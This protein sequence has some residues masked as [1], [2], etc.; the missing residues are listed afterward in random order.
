MTPFSGST[1]LKSRP[2]RIYSYSSTMSGFPALIMWISRSPI[3]VPVS[4]VMS[5]SSLPGH[6]CCFPQ[7]SVQ[8]LTRQDSFLGHPF[9][10][11]IAQR[12]S[13]LISS[14]ST[15]YCLAAAFRII[16]ERLPFCSRDLV[17]HK[18]FRNVCLLP[19]VTN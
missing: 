4:L 3:T 13:V 16:A 14:V 15:P 12:Y 19:R 17:Y 2:H 18:F 1:D 5:T 7:D 6:S 11:F 8:M 10:I 9:C